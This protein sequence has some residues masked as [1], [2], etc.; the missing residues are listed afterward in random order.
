MT[1]DEFWDMD[2]IEMSEA[3]QVSHIGRETIW[4]NGEDMSL[5]DWI[6]QKERKKAKFK[7]IQ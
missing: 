4:E 5:R 3:I 6:F 2:S 7:V 1:I